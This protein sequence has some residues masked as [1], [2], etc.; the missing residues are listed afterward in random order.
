[1]IGR[2]IDPDLFSHLVELNQRRIQTNAINSNVTM[3]ELG[4]NPD[5]KAEAEKEK[6]D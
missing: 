5:V 1:M 4:E 6:K 3:E 2:C